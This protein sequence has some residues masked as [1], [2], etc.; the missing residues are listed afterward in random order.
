MQTQGAPKPRRRVMRAVLRRLI[1]LGLNFFADIHISGKENL[2]AGGPLLV[3][4]NHFSFL[5]PVAMIHAMPWPLDFVGGLRMVN[6]PPI[7]RWIPGLWGVLPVRRGS[8][9][10]ET[11]VASR[12]I[13]NLNGVLGI[14]PEAGS[15]AAVLRP[16]RPG[17]AYLAS[18]TRAQILPIGFDGL[19]DLF[20]C[21]RRGERAQMQIRIGKPFGPLYASDRGEKDRARLEEIGHEIMRHIAPLIPPERRGFYSDDPAIRAAAKGTEIYPWAELHEQ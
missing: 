14:F 1:A 6:A 2:P 18:S 9:S 5:D 3:V 19:V 4:G 10:R 17:A 13:L 15:W 12:Q 7:V 11:L 16:A 21:F 8:L 20:P